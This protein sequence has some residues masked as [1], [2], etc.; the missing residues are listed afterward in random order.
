MLAHTHPLSHTHTHTHIHAFSF[1]SHV[2]RSLFKND[3][4]IVTAGVF[5]DLPNIVNMYVL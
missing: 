2:C 3:L 1:I 5:T 4:D